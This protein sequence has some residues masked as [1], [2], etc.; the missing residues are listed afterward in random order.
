MILITAANG[1]T[2]RHAIPR[3]V[4]K[5]EAVR[6]F[7]HSERARE[8]IKLGV[9]DLIVGDMLDPSAMKRAMTGVRAVVHVGPSFHPRETEMGVLAIDS[10]IAAGV[11]RFVYLSL[12]HPQLSAL[13]NHQVKLPVEEH[14]IE[15]DLDY[16]ILQPMHFMQNISV[17]AVIRAGA[18]WQ[19]YDLDRRVSH[20]DLADVAEVVVKVVT[21]QGHSGATYE[22]CGSD[23]LSAREIAKI[24][25]RESGRE[26][27]A[28]F[29]PL[30]KLLASEWMSRLGDYEKDS[31]RRLFEYYGRKGI[32]GNPNVL[33]WLLGRAP[34][35]LAGYVRREL[36]RAP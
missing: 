21:E 34:T 8:L 29:Q 10:A 20:V 22:L 28:R 16:T 19:S 17:P 6:A 32:F 27:E 1:K 3:L 33:A 36:Q 23:H 25:S 11:R 30:E 4:A 26:I 18:L 7:G 5:G 35:S 2:G 14:L 31:M 13:P 9:E 15:S 24:I 12:T